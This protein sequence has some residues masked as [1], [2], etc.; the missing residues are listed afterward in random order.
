MRMSVI[1]LLEGGSYMDFFRLI[2]KIVNRYQTPRY[3]EVLDVL[4]ISVQ[5]LQLFRNGFEML[6]FQCGEDNFLEES[7]TLREAHAFIRRITS[8]Q[9]QVIFEYK[10]VLCKCTGYI[11][12]DLIKG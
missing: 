3:I 2:L 5:E 1:P 8:N 11:I 7:V 12:K 6:N 10:T 4:K 9:A